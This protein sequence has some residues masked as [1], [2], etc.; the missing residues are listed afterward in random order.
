[1]LPTPLT[2]EPPMNDAISLPT[3]VSGHS[4][5]LQDGNRRTTRDKGMTDRSQTT[6]LDETVQIVD[7]DGPDDLQN[8]KK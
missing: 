8:P 6:T 2:D 7:W 5:S 3:N 4:E 1:M